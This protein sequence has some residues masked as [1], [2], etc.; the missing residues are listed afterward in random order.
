MFEEAA[1]FTLSGWNGDADAISAWNCCGGA[2]AYHVP[3]A[4]AGRD[5]AGRS[6]GNKPSES[7]QGMRNKVMMR[8]DELI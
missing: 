2:A 3:Y 4:A 5:A 8:T 7:K 1:A 6:L